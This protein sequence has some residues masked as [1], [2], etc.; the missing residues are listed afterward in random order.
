MG[1]RL[2]QAEDGVHRE[3]AIGGRLSHS[4]RVTVPLAIMPAAALLTLSV[5]MNFLPRCRCLS[6]LTQGHQ[7]WWRNMCGFE[8]RGT[9]GK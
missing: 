2:E 9:T 3:K 4:T 6:A 8:G 5:H 1:R 7:R